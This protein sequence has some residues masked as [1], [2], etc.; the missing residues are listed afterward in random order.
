MMLHKHVDQECHSVHSGSVHIF[1]KALGLCFCMISIESDG[2]KLL[3]DFYRGLRAKVLCSRGY[4]A[5]ADGKAVLCM[6]C[7]LC[8]YT[9]V[10]MCG[11][12]EMGRGVICLKRASH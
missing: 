8:M 7:V 11:G 12:Q 10:Y 1:S 3:Q 4:V 9:C 5:T 6:L 2:P